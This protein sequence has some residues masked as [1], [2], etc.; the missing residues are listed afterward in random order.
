MPNSIKIHPMFVPIFTAGT[1]AVRNCSG[2]YPTLMLDGV[3]RLV[4]GNAERG[5]RSTVIDRLGEA[6]DAPQ[7]IIVIGQ[8]ARGE[9][10]RYVEETVAVED[11]AGD[12]R[13][14]QAEPIRYLTVLSDD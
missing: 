9:F 8:L 2:T 1:I 7:R 6:D 4:R 12:L 11:G 14:S 10:D 13:T 3:S 5:D